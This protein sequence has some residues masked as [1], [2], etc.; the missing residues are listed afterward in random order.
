M[1]NVPFLIFYGMKISELKAP[2][3]GHKYRGYVK[4]VGGGHG[5]VMDIAVIH[6]IKEIGRASCRERV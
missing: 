4:T 1:R 6:E 5:Q 3:L 2:A